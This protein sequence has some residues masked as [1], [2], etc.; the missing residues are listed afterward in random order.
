M[1]DFNSLLRAICLVFPNTGAD[2][3]YFDSEERSV[4]F[5][6]ERDSDGNCLEI[7]LQQQE[8]IKIV[9]GAKNVRVQCLPCAGHDGFGCHTRLQIVLEGVTH[10]LPGNRS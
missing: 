10:P 9:F 4:W 1:T 5:I 2:T 3:L 8:I 6:P 7:S